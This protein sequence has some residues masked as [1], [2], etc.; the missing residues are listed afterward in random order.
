MSDVVLKTAWMRDDPALEADARAVWETHNL[1]AR[2]EDRAYRAR[3]LGVVAYCDGQTAAVATAELAMMSGLRARF[4]VCRVSV[5]PGLRRRQLSARTFGHLRTVL[6][7][8]SADHPQEKVMG[9]SAIIQAAEY[10]EK[11]RDP[12]WPDWGLFLTLAGYTPRNEQVRIAW[13]RHA[14]V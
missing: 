4:A 2:A 1:V 8:W 10:D 6:E 14:R 5:H 12:H 3:E 9:M 7:A 13:F 11:Q